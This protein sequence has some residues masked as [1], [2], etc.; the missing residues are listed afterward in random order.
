MSDEIVRR[1]GLD[2]ILANRQAIMEKIEQAVTAIREANEIYKQTSGKDHSSFF[3]VSDNAIRG[4]L[5]FNESERFLEESR[6]AVDSALW[7]MLLRVSGIQELMNASMLADFRE[8][9]KKDA[10]VPTRELVVDTFA[11]LHKNRKE[12]FKE[13]VVG[14]FEGLERRF[15][16]HDPYQFSDLL[17]FDGALSPHGYASY[18]KSEDEIADLERIIHVMRGNDPVQDRRDFFGSAI[19]LARR[20]GESF[21][22]NNEFEARLFKNGNLH[23]KIKDK[24]IIAS[25]NQILASHYGA[26]IPEDTRRTR[27]SRGPATEPSPSMTM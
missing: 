7:E 1:I 24:A 20:Q 9:L 15:K 11:S 5:R 6:N 25:L 10:P 21:V 23:L 2:E 14:V 17:I 26:A 8:Q 18:D 3:G 19:G 12:T 27:A 22:E 13:G 16:R 4:M